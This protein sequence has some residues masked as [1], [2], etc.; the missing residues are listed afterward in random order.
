MEIDLFAQLCSL[1]NLEIAFEKARKRKTLKKY[2]IDFEEH[3]IENLNTLRNELISK[4]YKPRPLTTFIIR[5]PKTRTISKSDFRD[6]VV[7][8]ALCNII[9]PLFDKHFIYDNYA[10]RKGKGV[11]KAIE[12][13]NHFKRKISQNNTKNCFILKAD[14][15]HYFENVSH[16]VLF[17]II[18]TKIQDENIIDLI[19]TILSNPVRG[20]GRSKIG[21]PLGNLTSQFF[22]NVYLNELDQFAKHQLKAEYYIRYVD[23]FV[24]LHDNK[25]ILEAYQEKINL[26]LK[27][28]LQL[29]LHPD[30]SKIVTLNQGITFL[31]FRIFPKHQLLRKKNIYKFERKLLQLKEDYQNDIIERDRILEVF[32]GWLEYA[33]HADAY[34]YKR[35]ITRQFN[36]FFPL[37]K[38]KEIK[39]KPKEERFSQKI[40]QT[41]YMFATQKTLQ[42]F[43]KKY[44]IAQ[45][46]ENRDIKEST[47]WDH[48]AKLIEYGQLSVWKIMS[49]KKVSIILKN[50][51]YPEDK[52]KE[53]KTKINDSSITFNEINCV[54]ASV[55]K[56]NKKRTI[57]H[58]IKWYKQVHCS[59]KCY[60]E[61]AQR[62][63]CS[64]KFNRL[65][66]QSDNLQMSKKEFLH[67]FNNNLKICILPEQEKLNYISWNHFVT[68]IRNA[69]R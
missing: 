18:K 61:P 28:N 33:S 14:I 34:K 7:H 56:K 55:K 5:D 65:I 21:M 32:E 59:R 16:E 23:D 8:H 43:K 22:A 29:E 54:L 37:D 19:T 42:L 45:I 46:A 3:L 41:T 11:L 62:A 57:A 12:R 66:T 9:E 6:R 63:L 4:I 30:K 51:Q 2:V 40:E 53:I 67:F 17:S 10:N 13:F 27:Q 64:I 49:G 20:G 60:F 26:F 52:L 15:K 69:K 36:Q 31:G 39:N 58:H 44:T 24:I 38:T 50:I 1:E 35:H 68:H 25:K 48:L 47:V